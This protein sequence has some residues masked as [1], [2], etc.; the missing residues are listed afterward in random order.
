M[1]FILQIQNVN[2]LLTFSLPLTDLM[3]SLLIFSFGSAL[4]NVAIQI[5]SKLIHF[6]VRFYCHGLKEPSRADNSNLVSRQF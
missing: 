1:I 3:L 6:L 2:L 4:F 5:I